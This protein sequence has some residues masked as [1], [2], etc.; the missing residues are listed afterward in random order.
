MDTYEKKYKEALELARVAAFNGHQSLMEG[1]FPELAESEDEKIRKFLIKWI[2]DNY[3]HGTTEI[4]TKT[5]IDWLEKQ[6]LKSNP[7]SGVSFSY[8]GN[9][10]GM[11]A[12]DNGVEISFDGELKAF[13]SSE[14]SF[15]YPA[16]PQPLLEPIKEEKAGNNNKVETKFKVGDY[17]ERKDGLG[18]HA[19]IIFVGGNVYGCEKLIYPK[20]SSPFFELTLENQ[21]EFKISPDFQQKHAWSEEDEA[22][23][24][25]IISD[26]A[27]AHKSSIG[28]NR[29]LKSLKQRIGG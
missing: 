23:L 26:F 11:C 2:Q 21:D 5:L 3:Y 20:D 1:I 28:Q 8:N 14:K 9:I 15:I 27:A 13:L 16:R 25:S 12:R 22:M 19:K 7:Y 17:I 6:E 4:P 29:W 10:W 24:V 18:C